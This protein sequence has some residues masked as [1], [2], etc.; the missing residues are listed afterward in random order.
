MKSAKTP[1][2]EARIRQLAAAL[3]GLS[4]STLDWIARV[5]AE[6]AR[7]HTYTASPGSDLVNAKFLSDFGDALRMHHCFSEEPFTKDKF[8]YAMGVIL[9]ASG[10]PA[11]LARK[12]NPGH[13]ITI[14]GIPVS[15]KTQADRSI[16]AS[17]IHISK[18]MELG[19]GKWGADVADLYGLRDQFLKHMHAYDRIFVLRYLAHAGPQRRY[20]LVEVPKALLQRAGGGDFTM[21]TGSR[22]TPPPGHCRVTENGQLLF[23]L[24]FDGGTER[25][26][27]I[28]H[29]LK[30]ECVVHAEWVFD[31]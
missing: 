16:K 10:H 31:R 1:E 2:R 29:L 15:L 24:Y 30:S 3:P 7:P 20:E 21:M 19:K 27:Q 28:L 14:D 17:E 13:D 22:Q 11:L 5:V 25:K 12:G 6:M 9:T 18:F 8:E 4:D 26:L 23:A